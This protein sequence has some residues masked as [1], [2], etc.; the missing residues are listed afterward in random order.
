MSTFTHRLIA[1]FLA[2]VLACLAAGSAGATIVASNTRYG[3]FDG[4]EGTRNLNVTYHGSILDLNLI[5]D[6]A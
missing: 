6:L 3:L 4:S 5:I 1:R 2:A